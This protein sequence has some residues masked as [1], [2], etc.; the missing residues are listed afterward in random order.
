MKRTLGFTHV[1]S[2]ISLASKAEADIKTVEGDCIAFGSHML[3]T[4]AVPGHTE[5]CTAYYIKEEGMVFTGDALM[6]RACGRTDF[7]GG[8]AVNLY[9]N[10]HA[11]LFNLPDET[12]VYPA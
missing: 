6:I 9:R 3:I 11:K 10:V 7:Q 5:G 2:V 12:K 1:K 4:I 8:S